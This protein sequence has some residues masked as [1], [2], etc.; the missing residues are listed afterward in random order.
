M[1]DTTSTADTVVAL[2]LTAAPASA[3]NDVPLT[4]ETASVLV[5]LTGHPLGHRCPGCCHWILPTT[6]EPRV[7]SAD[8]RG[9]SRF[10]VPLRYHEWLAY[11]HHIVTHQQLDRRTQVYLS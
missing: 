6:V 11:H 8:G 10:A 2:A 9:E 3:E 7:L 5:A 4:P 1:A